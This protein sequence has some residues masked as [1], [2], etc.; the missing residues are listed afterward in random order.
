M[1]GGA[2]RSE[3]AT[4][5]QVDGA[6]SAMRIATRTLKSLLLVSPSMPAWAAFAD[7][8][9]S[10]PVTARA[11]GGRTASASSGFAESEAVHARSGGYLIFVVLVLG[12]AVEVGFLWF[13]VKMKCD[14]DV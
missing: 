4:V 6:C 2:E 9:L 14:A 10:G 12:C 3:R 7:V 1:R 13:E 11:L 8:A 5:G